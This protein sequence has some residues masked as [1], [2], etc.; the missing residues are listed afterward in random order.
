MFNDGNFYI[1]QTNIANGDKFD[2]L[3]WTLATD[4]NI[5]SIDYI[6]YIPNDTDNVYGNDSSLKLDATGLISFG[7]DFD[8]SD[9]GEVLVVTAEYDNAPNKVL[10]YR[11]V[12]DNYQKYQEFEATQVNDGFGTQISVSQN[13]SMIAI[14]APNANT[15]DGDERGTVYI[16]TYNPKT[17]VREF[18][19]TQTLVSSNP[20]RG[21]QFG[22]NIDFD[23]NM[24]YVSAF[25][26]PSDDETMFD[27]YQERLYP[28][29]IV[30]KNTS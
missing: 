17:D 22:G 28:E 9:D 7:K 18:E 20:I 1:A 8:I 30:K 2:I 27:T 25:A 15:L 19:L 4:D 14:S 23:G 13:G 6:G 24:L 16:Y 5:R 26:S 11:N 12:N 29:S 3:D 21:E 10:V